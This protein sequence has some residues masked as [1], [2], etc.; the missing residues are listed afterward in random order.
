M[1]IIFFDFQVIAFL[2]STIEEL[3]EKKNNLL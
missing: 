3:E 2:E 1:K